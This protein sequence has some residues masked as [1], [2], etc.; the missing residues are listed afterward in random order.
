VVNQQQ[1]SRRQPTRTQVAWIGIGIVAVLFVA[2]VVFGGYY[3]EWKWTGYPKRTPWDWVDLLIVPVVLALG[4]YLFTR[5]ETRRTQEIAD[6]Q[7][8]DD[9]LQAY[10]DGMAQLLADKER[11]LHR[12]RPDDNLSVGARA[13][14]LT[15]LSRLD[16]S[17]KRNVLQFL[18]EAG[19]I[20]TNRVV[21]DLRGAALNGADLRGADLSGAN[22]RKANLRGA[23]LSEATL[24]GTIPFAP[25][26]YPPRGPADLSYAD[27]R[28]ANLRGADLYEARLGGANLRGADLYEARLGGAN[29]RGARG[30]TNEDLERQTYR[31]EGATMPNGQRYEVWLKSKSSGEDGENRGPS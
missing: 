18:Y 7:R 29:L 3:F 24:S 1:Q 17:R 20:T 14:T 5:S 2:V 27:L 30:I 16:N 4:G 15:A 31:L 8:Q 6:E 21:L 12:A 9:T 13:R 11:P 22:L 28:K 10:L 25:L 23:T 19:L 26:M